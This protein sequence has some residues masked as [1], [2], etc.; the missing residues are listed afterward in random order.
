LIAPVDDKTIAKRLRELRKRRG[1]T[2]TEI[3]EKLGLNQPL[4]SQ[5]ERGDT[6]LHGSLVAA[7]ARAL[8]V[9]SDE[10]LGLQDSRDNSIFTDRR[11]L[12]RLRKMEDLSRR[13]KQ[14]LIRI[15]DGFLAGRARSTSRH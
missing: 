5:Y 6:R 14:A 3:A 11:F 7:L 9:P 12:R 15:I 10:I 2:Q 1:F 13:D 8:K 4:V